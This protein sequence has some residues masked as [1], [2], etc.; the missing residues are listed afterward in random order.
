MAILKYIWMFVGYLL[1][2]A[3]FFIIMPIEV[4]IYFFMYEFLNVEFNKNF[5]P[6]YN[7]V[8]NFILEKTN[9]NDRKS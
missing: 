7:I 8:V 1:C 6:L 4:S 3:V 2:C 5:N 9:L